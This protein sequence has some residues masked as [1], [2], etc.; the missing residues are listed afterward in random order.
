MIDWL[1]FELLQCYSALK[2]T[3]HGEGTLW[4]VVCEAIVAMIDQVYREA[5]YHRASTAFVLGSGSV[6]L[7]LSYVLNRTIV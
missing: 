5:F 2:S 6:A 4:T 3:S 7:R 1:E